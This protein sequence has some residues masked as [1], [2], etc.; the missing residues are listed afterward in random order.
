MA[1]PTTSAGRLSSLGPRGL[2]R[3]VIW[4][5][6]AWGTGVTNRSSYA[7]NATRFVDGLIWPRIASLIKLDYSIRYVSSINLIDELNQ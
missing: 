5:A 1:A 2:N 4:R 7:G 3:A 6:P